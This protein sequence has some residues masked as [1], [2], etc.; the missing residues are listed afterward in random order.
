MLLLLL[1]SW[2]QAD[3]K[4]LRKT[5]LTS[6]GWRE[7]RAMTLADPRL[8]LASGAHV[9]MMSFEEAYTYLGRKTRADGVDKQAWTTLKAKFKGADRRLARIK[10]GAV[11]QREFV[12]LGDTLYGGPA[13]SWR[14]STLPTMH[15]GGTMDI[16]TAPPLSSTRRRQSRLRR[17][18]T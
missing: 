5:V 2:P 8:T 1:P 17:A 4:A 15:A 18:S 7:G 12:L 16:S 3:A 10:R 6:I 13:S 11:S 14:T 9:P